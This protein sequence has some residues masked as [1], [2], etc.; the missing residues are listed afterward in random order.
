[1][2]WDITSIDFRS[3]LKAVVFDQTDIN[4]VEQVLEWDSTVRTFYIHKIELGCLCGRLSLCDHSKAGGSKIAALRC[5]TGGYVTDTWDFEDD[6]LAVTCEVTVGA[7]LCISAQ[8]A[9]VHGMVKYELG[10]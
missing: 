3:G 10:N 4:A 5:I 7:G 8:A 1:M 6:P 2:A 9:A